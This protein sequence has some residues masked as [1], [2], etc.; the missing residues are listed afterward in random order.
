[1]LKVIGASRI[2][3]ALK[4]NVHRMYRYT[5]VCPLPCCHICWNATTMHMSCQ[6]ND[7]NWNDGNTYWVDRN[8]FLSVVYDVKLLITIT[9]K[10]YIEY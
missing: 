2:K 3:W 9:C 5:L 7:T 8:Y 4:I 6:H 10:R 1:M